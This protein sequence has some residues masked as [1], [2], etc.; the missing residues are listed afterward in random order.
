M[1]EDERGKI[2][3][4]LDRLY[5]CVRLICDGYTIGLVRIPINPTT[6]R[7][8]VYINGGIDGKHLLRDCEERRRFYCPHTRYVLPKTQRE[9]LKRLGPY[10]LAEAGIDPDQTLTSYTPWWAS[11]VRLVRHLEENNTDISIVATQEE[12]AP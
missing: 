5:S 10:G 8:L 1:T 7:V 4:T 11:S 12:V 2:I 3:Q 9:A 6:N